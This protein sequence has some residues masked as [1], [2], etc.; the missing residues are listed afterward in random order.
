MSP[1]PT[2]PSITSK[3]ASG[4]TILLALAALPASATPTT[5]AN[6]AGDYTG[7]TTLPAGWSYFYSSQTSGATEYALTPNLALGSATGGTNIGFGTSGGTLNLPGVL[8]TKIPAAEFE[9]FTDGHA[10]A[11]VL[12]T[13]LVLHPGPDAATSTIIL[14]YTIN[15]ANI[16]AYGNSAS[17]A[18]S[19]RDLV[20]GG[21]SII[22]SIYHNTTQLFTKTGSATTGT[23][24]QADGTFNISDLTVAANDTISFVLNSNNANWGA[25]E[26]ALRGTIALE[27]PLPANVTNIAA[28]TSPSS[29]PAGWSYLYSDMASGGTEVAMTPNLALGNGGNSG[30]GRVASGIFNLPGVIG[31]QAGAQY[32]MFLDGDLNAP[33]LGTDLLIH[34]GPDAA[35]NTVILRYTI[36]AAR[37]AAYGNCASIAGSFRKLIVNGDSV[38]V[39]IYHNTTQVFAKPASGSTLTQ[40]DGTFNISGLAVAANDTISF[41][42]N[43]NANIASDETALRGTI[44]LENW[45]GAWARGTFAAPFTDTAKANDP[46]LDGLSNLMEY[47]FG[48]DPTVSSPGLIA[49]TDAVVTAHGRPTTLAEGGRYYAVFG[50]RSD[51]VA[52]GL[53]YTVQFSAT[54]TEGEWTDGSATP[55]QIASDG[56]IDVMKVPYQNLIITPR[57]VEKPT[58][59]RMKVTQNP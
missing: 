27:V 59:F 18:G 40:A 31:T 14:R 5:V 11:P 58:F 44:T 48:I 24:T 20:A 19:F 17:I 43:A 10:N 35:N 41:V 21:N 12:G 9:I 32:E 54:M 16:A 45:Y 52:A 8:G 37:I 30:F 6:I 39:S 26:S 25:D 57:G 29:V 51:H 53:T 47:A 2:K 4:V 22:V 28:I 49:Y 1:Q 34:P 3:I 38:A 7:P 56:V 33:A 23:L 42:V 15:A 46:D 36:S 13:D 50:R 55:T